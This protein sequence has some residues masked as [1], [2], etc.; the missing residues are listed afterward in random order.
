MTLS[1]ISF[2]LCQICL[3]VL[4]SEKPVKCKGV[5]QGFFHK[6]CVEKARNGEHSVT[7]L[8][9]DRKKR[10]GK[11]LTFSEVSSTQSEEG[12]SQSSDA[13]QKVRELD[14]DKAEEIEKLEVKEEKLNEENKSDWKCDDCIQGENPCFVCKSKSGNRQRCC[15][16]K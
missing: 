5:C 10:R 1:L 9:S 12:S 11:R 14:E 2:Q 8:N 4:E 3:I 13:D 16:G 6:S 7:V 15:V